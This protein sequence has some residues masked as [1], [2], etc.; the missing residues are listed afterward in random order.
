[1]VITRAKLK[2]VDPP[3]STNAI[4][5]SSVVPDVIVVR[6]NVVLRAE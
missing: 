6:L 1:M 2:I 3:K 5:T 4:K